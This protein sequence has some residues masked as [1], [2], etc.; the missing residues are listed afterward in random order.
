ML[1]DQSFQICRLHAYALTDFPMV[2]HC[3]NYQII[4]INSGNA[5]YN[6]ATKSHN[7]SENNIYYIC[8]N[9]S[10]QLIPEQELDGYIISFNSDFLNLS[11]EKSLLSANGNF[12]GLTATSKF[13]INASTKTDIY[14]I[15]VRIERECSSAHMLKSEVIKGLLRLLLIYLSR[16]PKETVCTTTLKKNNEIVNKFFSILEE[17]YNTHHMAADYAD[18]LYV[19]SNFLNEL[20]KKTSGYTTRYHIHRRIIIEAKRQTLCSDSSMKEIAYELGFDDLAHFS[21]FFK[22]ATGECF[23]DF[24]KRT[25]AANYSA[26]SEF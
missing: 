26:Q 23:K 12:I 2:N 11:V 5:I 21:K 16:I 6:V 25:F 20:L 1:K 22:N 18:M 17:K 14:K 13:K 19:T 24:K 9:P 4:F 8:P 7:L 15:L 10:Y 3:E